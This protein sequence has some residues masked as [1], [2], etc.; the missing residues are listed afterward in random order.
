[1]S[2]LEVTA[3]TGQPTYQEMMVI[4]HEMFQNVKAIPGFSE[5]MEA[6]QKL[7]KLM[8]TTPVPNAN[9]SPAL[10]PPPTA[11]QPDLP[12]RPLILPTHSMPPPPMATSVSPAP[13]QYNLNV[14][15][16]YSQLAQN[17]HP[18]KPLTPL[19]RLSLTRPQRN[20][21]SFSN[22][23]NAINIDTFGKWH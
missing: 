6:I 16:Q 20:P 7:H 11:S 17:N 18:S 14:I 13:Q 23:S 22:S 19:S 1:M 12:D 2:F 5:T 21:W 15:S 8:P 9:L 4:H 3:C 10:I